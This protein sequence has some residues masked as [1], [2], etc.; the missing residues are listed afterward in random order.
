MAVL[1]SSLL[2][3]ALSVLQGWRMSVARTPQVARICALFSVIDIDK[4]TYK[5][6]AVI[7]F[8]L[9]RRKYKQAKREFEPLLIDHDDE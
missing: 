4:E 8:L 3:L 1:I 7:G 9:A 6:L 5:A 2:A